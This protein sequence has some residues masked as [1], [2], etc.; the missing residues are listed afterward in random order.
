M[1]L[2]KKYRESSTNMSPNNVDHLPLGLSTNFTISISKFK[3]R[4]FRNISTIRFTKLSI[5][6]Y[7]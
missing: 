1:K 2:F 3:S 4:E 7:Y 5:S 6:K